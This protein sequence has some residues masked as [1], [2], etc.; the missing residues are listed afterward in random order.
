MSAIWRLQKLQNTMFAMCS[1]SNVFAA[2][3]NVDSCNAT[4]RKADWQARIQ[5]LVNTVRSVLDANVF[6]CGHHIVVE[7]LAYEEGIRECKGVA[8]S[9][10]L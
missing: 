3:K 1:E 2:E 10:C 5:E 6:W 7:E 9:G 4:K 8:L